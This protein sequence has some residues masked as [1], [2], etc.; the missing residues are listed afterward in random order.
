[1]LYSSCFRFTLHLPQESRVRCDLHGGKRVESDRYE[2]HW[3]L[4]ATSQLYFKRQKFILNTPELFI[5]SSALD[6][7]FNYG[8]LRSQ[9]KSQIFIRLIVNECNRTWWWG[10]DV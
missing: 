7:L 2:G 4:V 5:L 8:F 6:V 10:R 1:M 3:K 9:M